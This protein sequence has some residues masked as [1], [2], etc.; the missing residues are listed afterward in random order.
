MAKIAALLTGMFEDDEYTE[1]ADAFKGHGDEVINVGLKAGETVQGERGRAS[2]KIDRPVE[3]ASINDFDVLFIPGGFSPD[4]LRVHEAAV[5]FA[6]DFLLSGK[7]VFA[8][9]HAPQLFITANVLKGR[10]LAGWRS[11]IQDIRNAG[12]E[13]VDQPVV[14][15]G[16]LISSRSPADIPQFI[17]ACLRVLNGINVQ[18]PAGVR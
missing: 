16:N 3:E 13:Y 11:I 5:N 14:I 18:Q 17:E 7:P 4:R 12:G 6:R 10:K 2:T 8:I 15:D 9:C 1:P